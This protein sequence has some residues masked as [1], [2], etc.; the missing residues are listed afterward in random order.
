MMCATEQLIN[1]K[2]DRSQLRVKNRRLER[3]V[4]RL[5]LTV[6]NLKQAKFHLMAEN[7]KLKRQVHRFDHLMSENKKLK[8]QVKHIDTKLNST[9]NGQQH[10]TKLKRLDTK[11]KRK[12]AMQ[13]QGSTDKVQKLDRPPSVLP[14]KSTITLNRK[15]VVHGVSYQLHEVAFEW[16]SRCS[17][18]RSSR[19]GV[20]TTDRYM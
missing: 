8:R 18:R 16:A 11:S 15:G 3:Q 10:S 14:K 5:R 19:R 20:A 17:S 9:S 1:L 6:G 7:K 13:L 12:P 2:E 4:H